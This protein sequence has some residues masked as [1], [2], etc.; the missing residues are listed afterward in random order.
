MKRDFTIG[1]AWSAAGGWIEQGVG[2][3]IFLV[4]ARLVGVEDFGLA[5]MAFAFLFLGEFLVRDTLTEA[6]VERRT[7]ED[8]RLEATLV[9]LTGF[10]LLIILALG[11]ISLL[12][13]EAYGERTVGP[14]LMAA[15]PTVLMILG[16]VQLTPDVSVGK[17][18]APRTSP[19]VSSGKAA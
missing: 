3:V 16:S 7:L 11:F 2:A 14:L 6:I 13:A 19:T 12:A 17:R 10:S 18:T 4:V 5:A 15:S 1:A 8:G 9:A